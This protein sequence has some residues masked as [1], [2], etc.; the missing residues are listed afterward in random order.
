MNRS[1]IVGVLAA[2]LASGGGI[3]GQDDADE[4]KA[5]ETA[6][7][8]T[9]PTKRASPPK[10]LPVPSAAAQQRALEQIKEVFSTE[11]QSATTAT[12]KQAFALTLFNQAAKTERDATARYVL[13]RQSQDMAAAAGDI[14]AA[15][16][17]LDEAAKHFATDPLA[18]KFELLK[19]ASRSS[20]GQAAA[21]L[22]EHIVP[23]VDDAMASERF[24]LARD[25]L[26]LATALGRAKRDPSLNRELAQRTGKINEQ[27]KQWDEAK[28]A[29]EKLKTSPGDAASNHKLG[30]YRV[31]VKGDWESGLTLLAKGPFSPLRKAAELDLAHPSESGLRVQLADAWWKLAESAPVSEK[32]RLFERA[33]LWY[34]RALPELVDLE[35]VRVEKRLE[36]ISEIAAGG[37]ESKV[38]LGKD[39]LDIALAPGHVQRFR[40]VPRGQLTL[41]NGKTLSVTRPF[42]LAITEITQAQWQAV[43]GANPARRKGERLPVESVSYQD[44]EQFMQRLNGARL[45]KLRFRFPTETEWEFACRAGTT[46]TFHFGDDEKLLP[47]YEWYLA[48]ANKSS[49]VVGGLKPNRA[50]LY[51]MAGNVYE[52]V[53][54]EI[55]RGGCGQSE[56]RQCTSSYRYSMVG[57]AAPDNRHPFIGLRLVC[58]PQ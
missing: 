7:T 56:P 37:G 29:A 44:C 40:L 45:G 43:M 20:T 14:D 53:Q 26:R 30:R 6:A 17:A 16:K 33:K 31:F 50:G 19:K 4:P 52:W 9:A 10:K 18:D 51:D 49:Q 25:L 21:E 13:L 12:Q 34:E 24:D 15:L 47:Q 23:H 41:S 54:G 36:K 58:E 1:I 46:T 48:N 38:K 28:K 22:L 5:T 2:V 39:V 3:L 57:V 8:E 32:S 42:Y 55:I 11:Y 27:E 35:K